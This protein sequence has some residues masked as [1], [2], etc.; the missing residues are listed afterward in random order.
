[1][2]T[3][4]VI[5]ILVTLQ[6]STPCYHL[7]IP[8][9]MV[10]NND[11]K[12]E[13]IQLG[14]TCFHCYQVEIHARAINRVIKRNQG[15]LYMTSERQNLQLLLKQPTRI[16]CG[17]DVN[18]MVVMPLSIDASMTRSHHRTQSSPQLVCLRHSFVPFIAGL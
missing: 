9:C 6:S 5:L 4:Q 13:I 8:L 10:R 15:P 18:F 12:C 7:L 2:S 11:S 17:D 1:M 14:V 3:Q 16:F